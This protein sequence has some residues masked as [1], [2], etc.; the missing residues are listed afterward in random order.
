M[1]NTLDTQILPAVIIILMSSYIC[2]SYKPSDQK[3][4]YVKFLTPVSAEL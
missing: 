4:R 1:A 3:T 2:L